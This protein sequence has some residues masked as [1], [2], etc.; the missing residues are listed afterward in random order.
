MGL[1]LNEFIRALYPNCEENGE[2]YDLDLDRCVKFT[3]QTCCYVDYYRMD[4]NFTIWCYDTLEDLFK[5]SYSS[6]IFIFKI[7]C[8]KEV[9]NKLKRDI[10]YEELDD[11]LNSNPSWICGDYEASDRIL[12]IDNFPNKLNINFKLTKDEFL[13]ASKPTSS[14]LEEYKSK[15]Y[16]NICTGKLSEFKDLYDIDEDDDDIN[17]GTDYNIRI[18]KVITDKSYTY[19]LDVNSI[20]ESYDYENYTIWQYYVPPSNIPLKT[21]TN[22]LLQRFIHSINNF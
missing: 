15:Y 13:N 20:K 11:K 9:I 5:N 21:I 18:I 17:E 4:T 12:T 19:I 1:N 10:L 14:E 7:N 22:L 2:I 6:P 16:V 3:D 8:T